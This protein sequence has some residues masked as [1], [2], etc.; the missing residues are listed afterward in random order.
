MLVLNEENTEVVHVSSGHIGRAQ[1]RVSPT[2]SRLHRSGIRMLYLIDLS[3][4][5]NWSVLSVEQH[6]WLFIKLEKFVI[7]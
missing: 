7:C 6:I 5:S 2:L 1:D 4:C 3:L